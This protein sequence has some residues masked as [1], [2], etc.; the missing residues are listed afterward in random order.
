MKSLQEASERAR[1]VKSLDVCF[2]LDCTNSMQPYIDS[3]KR[4]ISDINA[5]IQRLS[6]SLVGLEALS[7][8]FRFQCARTRVLRTMLGS[9]ANVRY[10]MVCYRD[11]DCPEHEHPE[12]LPFGDVQC[13][14]HFLSRIQAKGGEDWRLGEEMKSQAS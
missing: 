11:F 7:A 10:A 8:F 9:E 13:C 12:T 14:Q 6:C 4:K 5:Q 1:K 3:V 2:V